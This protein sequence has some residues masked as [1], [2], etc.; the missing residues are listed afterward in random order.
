MAPT[1]HK[2]RAHRATRGSSRA[3]GW[4]TGYYAPIYAGQPDGTSSNP[5]VR[6][7]SAHTFRPLSFAICHAALSCARGEARKRAVM[8]DDRRAQKQNGLCNELSRTW[9]GKKCPFCSSLTVC[10]AMPPVA[11]THTPCRAQ[12]VHPMSPR[13]SPLGV[14][15]QPR[16]DAGHSGGFQRARGFGHTR[17]GPPGYT[18]AC[19]LHTRT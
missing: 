15:S 3:H 2:P 18:C 5:V 4:G 9:R 7:H 17:G 13:R 10:T 12:A 8:I 16:M 19:K 11:V 6:A 1:E 14:T